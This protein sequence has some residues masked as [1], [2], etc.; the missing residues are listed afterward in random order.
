MHGEFRKE[1][2]LAELLS[3]VEH[4]RGRKTLTMTQLISAVMEVISYG[5]GQVLPSDT[6]VSELAE[7]NFIFASAA[8][9]NVVVPPIDDLAVMLESHL[10]GDRTDATKGIS[11][12]WEVVVPILVKFTADLIL[13][14]FVGKKNS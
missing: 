12:P 5:L 14:Y 6:P 8:S 9:D 11:V 10:M 1:F 4:F 7:P 13:R 2:P 3:L